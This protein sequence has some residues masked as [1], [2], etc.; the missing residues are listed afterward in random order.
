MPSFLS[1]GF[2]IVGVIVVEISVGISVGGYNSNGSRQS[3][4][5]QTSMSYE[6]YKSMFISRYEIL[7]GE[8]RR[9]GLPVGK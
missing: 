3:H 5:C 4:S 2:V 6:H 7:T 9:D 8:G 1:G